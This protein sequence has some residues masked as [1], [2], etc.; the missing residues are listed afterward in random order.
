MYDN[1]YHGSTH[2]PKKKSGDIHPF[3]DD[4]YL[5]SRSLQIAEVKTSHELIE[6][7]SKNDKKY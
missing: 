4:H 7:E 1:Y 3:F 5:L 6:L 2:A